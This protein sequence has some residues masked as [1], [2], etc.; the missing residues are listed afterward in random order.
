M[1]NA[2]EKWAWEEFGQAQLG[3]KRRT[4]RLVEIA[5]VLAEQPTPSISQA[6]SDRAGLKATYPLL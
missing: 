1:T 3:D 6:S 4:D 2:T 5:Q